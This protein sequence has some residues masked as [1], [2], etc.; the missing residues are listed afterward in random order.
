MQILETREHNANGLLHLGND[1][2]EEPVADSE[3]ERDSARM[4]NLFAQ[5][6]GAKLFPT[7]KKAS[8]KPSP[9]LPIP[10]KKHHHLYQW[11]CTMLA[12]G[13]A[14]IYLSKD[15]IAS[16]ARLNHWL[17]PSPIDSLLKVEQLDDIA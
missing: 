4:E 7:D 13:Y 10:S 8:G 1:L 16:A 12:T 14:E 6:T 9:A 2:L 3:V 5:L 17:S 15:A 11:F